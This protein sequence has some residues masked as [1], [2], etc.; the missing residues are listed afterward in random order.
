MKKLLVIASLFMATMVNAQG[1][2]ESGMM[3]G[4]GMMKDAKSPQ[5]LTDTEAFFERIAD[6]EK[7]QWLPYYYAAL[8]QA[9]YAFAVGADD[10]EK[11]CAKAEDLINK[12][13]A[14]EKNN[15][16]IA[17]VKAMIGTNRM[18]INPQANYMSWM[19]SNKA[20]MSDAKKFD[21]TNPRPYFLEGQTVMGTP[22]QFGG[23][24]AAAKPIFTKAVELYKNFKPVTPFSPTWGSDEATKQLAAC[25]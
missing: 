21:P 13:E 6:A 22:E 2:F 18:L 25:N 23:G 20:L 3:K 24:K 7:T 15:S 10:K 5:E 11:A 9:Q 14:L 1:K 17:C 4:L 8:A 19:G 16:E 12:A